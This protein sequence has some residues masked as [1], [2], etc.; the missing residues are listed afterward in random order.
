MLKGGGNQAVFLNTNSSHFK[1][2]M[3]LITLLIINNTIVPYMI[4]DFSSDFSNVSVSLPALRSDNFRNSTLS[5]TIVYY[6]YCYYLISKEHC[7]P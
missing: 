2:S 6:Y 7:P 1:S 5:H 3:F 4:K